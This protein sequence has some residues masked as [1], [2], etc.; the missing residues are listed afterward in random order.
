MRIESSSFSV[1][2]FVNLGAEL[3]PEAPRPDAP[4]RF[5]IRI[6]LSGSQGIDMPN[7]QQGL[8]VKADERVLSEGSIN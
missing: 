5:R 4:S 6:G 7:S 8:A 1:L 2:A 3:L